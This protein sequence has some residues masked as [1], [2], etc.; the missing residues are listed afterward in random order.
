M[1]IC[2]DTCQSK[3]IIFKANLKLCEIKFSRD[4]IYLAHLLMSKSK[5][6][7][8]RKRA[9]RKTS[10]RKQSCQA[11]H[12]E[13]RSRNMQWRYQDAGTHAGERLSQGEMC[14]GEAPGKNPPTEYSHCQVTHSDTLHEPSLSIQMSPF[15]I[16]PVL[17]FT[18]PASNLTS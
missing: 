8:Q 9:G 15:G 12:T 1:R 2:K 18:R 11:L 7:K 16:S 6:E 4:Y 5:M 17:P 10:S 13:G 3:E 14:H